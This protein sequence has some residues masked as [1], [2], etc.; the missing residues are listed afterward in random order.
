MCSLVPC[1]PD[2]TCSWST[3]LLEG[4]LQHFQL[5]LHGSSLPSSA[6]SPTARQNVPGAGRE[7]PTLKGEW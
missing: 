5:G 6:V 7:M 2:I 1:P 3:L 4:V